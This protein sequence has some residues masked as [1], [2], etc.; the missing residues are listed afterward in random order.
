VASQHCDSEGQKP[1]NAHG[2][3]NGANRHAAFE[4]SP[5]YD[6]ATGAPNG[7]A[8]AQTEQ[9]TSL[10]L[11]PLATVVSHPKGGHVGKTLLITPDEQHPR[12]VR[13]E[14]VTPKPAS[15]FTFHS[16]WCE[17]S[18]E[19]RADLRRDLI[20]YP[21]KSLIAGVP[22][23][24][25]WQKMAPVDMPPGF[26][27]HD[28]LIDF[29]RLSGKTLIDEPLPYLTI[30]MDKLN[31][32]LGDPDFDARIDL[33]RLDEILRSVFEKTCY[34]FLITD[35]VYMAS[36]TYGVLEKTGKEYDSPCTGHPDKA[37]RCHVDWL[38]RKPKT[39]A[40]QKQFV[41]MFNHACLCL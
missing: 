9:H 36:S 28:S 30:D 31:G 8:G 32:C 23:D 21:D 18:L 29:R 15:S 39:L 22:S 40:Q 24:E 4:Q 33:S 20:R 38:L 11:W 26:V 16:I 17:R 7:A 19:M 13:Y 25:V 3:S 34:E 5:N 41:I 6:D 2:A 37:V 35:L 10:D 1:D 12:G 27:R 14:D